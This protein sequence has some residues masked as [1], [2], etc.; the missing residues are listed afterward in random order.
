MSCV[1]KRQIAGGKTDGEK[2]KR[3]ERRRRKQL[4]MEGKV[5]S[6]K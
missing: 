1:F 6:E 2:K 5:R 3:G 4:R